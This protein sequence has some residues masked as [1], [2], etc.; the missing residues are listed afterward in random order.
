VTAWL[1]TISRLLPNHT[2][3]LNDEGE[4]LTKRLV[5]KNGKARSH[6]GNVWRDVGEYCKQVFPQDFEQ[7]PEFQ[8]MVLTSNEDGTIFSN[9][10]GSQIWA[11]FE[12]EYF[13][14]PQ[15]HPVDMVK[16][17]NWY[18]DKALAEIK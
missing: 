11:G 8:T 12:G 6:R 3:K 5:I 16:N 18:G 4:F 9:G 2:F 10:G 14:K 13:N 1:T 17:I 7:H 15:A